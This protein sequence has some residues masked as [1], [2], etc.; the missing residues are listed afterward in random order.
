MRTTGVV[1]VVD[2]TIVVNAVVGVLHDIGIK[3]VDDNDVGG[4]VIVV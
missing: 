1:T 2:L 4:A 3:D